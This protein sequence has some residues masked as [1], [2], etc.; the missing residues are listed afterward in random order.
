MSDF[1]QQ[2]R[3]RALE[4]HPSL[5]NLADKIKTIVPEEGLALYVEG[6]TYPEREKVCSDFIDKFADKHT[7]YVN[8]AVKEMAWCYVTSSKEKCRDIQE[9]AAIELAKKQQNEVKIIESHATLMSA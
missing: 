7:I 5:A 9:C 4:H 3:N 6:M 2:R 8:D 1:F